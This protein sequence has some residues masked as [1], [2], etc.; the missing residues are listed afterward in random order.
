MFALR[1]I[2]T[3]GA[4]VK[5]DTDLFG[6]PMRLHSDG[7]VSEKRALFAPQFFDIQERRAVAS[8]AADNAVFIDIGANMALYSFSTAATFKDYKN[9][10]I[11]A[12]EPHPILSDRLAYNLSLNPELPIEQITLG[13][14][15][16]DEKNYILSPANNLGESRLLNKNE[17]AVGEIYEIQVK[18]LMSLLAENNIKRIDGIKIDIEGSEEAVLSPFLKQAPETLLPRIIIIEKNYLKW[19]ED[20]IALAKCR[21]YRESSSTR[22]NT[23]LRKVK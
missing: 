20:L 21:G 13:L 8:L 2:A 10:R 12:I 4:N 22:M 17:T 19:K 6:F 7:N 23:I 15:D 14:G 18:T 5:V 1:K 9:T 3:F 11:L 16:R